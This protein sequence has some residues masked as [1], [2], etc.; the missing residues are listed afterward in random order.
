M[1]TGKITITK[2]DG[3]NY[4]VWATQVEALLQARGLWQHI[5]DGVSVPSATEPTYAEFM[6]GRNMVR[7]AIICSL[8]PEY[9][10]MVA[11]ERDP[12]E[13]WN[14]LA[15]MHKS[16]CT[17]SVHSLRNRLLNIKMDQSASIR[18]FVNE[19]CS[20]ERQLAFAGKIIHEGDKKY[21]LLNGLRQEYHVKKA[22][23]Q[24]RYDTSFEK[25]VSSLEMTEDELAS[26]DRR[27]NGSSSSGSAFI[28]HGQKGTRTMKCWICE[29]QGHKMCDCFYNPK[30]KKFKPTM[31]PSKKIDDNLRKKNLLSGDGHQRKDECEFAF[32]AQETSYIQN[33]WFL[34]SCCSRHV[35]NSMD[36]MVNYKKLVQSE[37]ISCASEGES[38]QVIGV[39]NVWLKQVIDGKERVT[40][41]KDV[42]Y[43][44]N[45]RTNLV[46]LTKAQRVGVEIVYK[47]GGSR[48][49]ATYNGRV[50]MHGD[51]KD[52]GISELTGMETAPGGRPNV[53]FFNAGE[54]DAMKLAHRRMCHTSVSMLRKM[55]EINAVHGLDA[56]KTTRNVGHICEACVDGK[57]TNKPHP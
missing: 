19:I 10:P 42:G 35:T 41:L 6:K 51:S 38:V 57:A 28:T 25:M 32:M 14:K 45:C 17:A 7:S 27:S 44:P 2:L 29:R 54:D 43:A 5:E 3:T 21:A 52:T 33:K 18:A 15:D 4:L 9:V 1:D 16:K 40:M 22:I 55:Q 46:S 49:V 53:A 30:S 23:L 36:G 39:G 31:K 56:V 11:A 34:D 12:K 26:K 24:E 20:I 48:M 8:E 37:S 47:G 13:I 50:V